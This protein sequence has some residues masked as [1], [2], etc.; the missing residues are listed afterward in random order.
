LPATLA[1][2]G[3]AAASPDVRVWGDF[4]RL[5]HTGDASAQ[6]VLA[7]AGIGQGDYGVGALAQMRGEIWVWDGRALVSR[8]HDEA[9]RTEPPREGDA[10]AL[11]A[12]VRVK[13]WREVPVP[14]DL[15]QPEFERFVLERA[16]A[17]RIDVQRPF[18]FAVRG[19]LA[20]L[21][22]HVVTGAASGA[23]GARH[24]MGHAV[25]RS[26]TAARTEGVLLGLYSAAALEGVVSHPGERFHLHFATPDFTRSGH[27]DAYAVV[28]GAVLLLPAPQ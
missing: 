2:F 25:N 3:A 6:V 12:V 7:D 10:A 19:P 21:T 8:G 11:L 24:A 27:V 26:F 9:G 13:S 5:M 20:A 18:A 17:L 16:Q 22:W 1:T 23:H 15:P 4:S 14:R 28:A